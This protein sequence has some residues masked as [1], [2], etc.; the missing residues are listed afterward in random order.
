MFILAAS[1]EPTDDLLFR[2]FGAA[3][4]EASLSLHRCN[5]L[6]MGTDVSNDDV[7]WDKRLPRRAGGMVGNG[8]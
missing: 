2:S 5:Y 1:K 3:R 4:H 6:V 8:S 7:G